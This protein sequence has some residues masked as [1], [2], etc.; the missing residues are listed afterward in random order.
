MIWIPLL[1]CYISLGDFLLACPHEASP[2]SLCT[3]IGVLPGDLLRV[4]W[5]WTATELSLI[6]SEAAVP[7]LNSVHY[8]NL[9]QCGIMEVT[10]RFLSVPQ[11]CIKL[12]N[13]AAFVFHADALEHEYVNYA[14]MSN[15]FF[16]SI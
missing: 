1:K 11:I 5:L 4:C 12:A 7:P 15:V 9:Q 10:E 8:P 16:Y 2:C 14:G 13:E 6:V 3:V